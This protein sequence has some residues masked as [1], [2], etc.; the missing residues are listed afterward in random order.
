MKGFILTS[1]KIASILKSG[2]LYN[3]LRLLSESRAN[4][5]DYTIKCASF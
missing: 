3:M 5:K 4:E 1:K 2:E